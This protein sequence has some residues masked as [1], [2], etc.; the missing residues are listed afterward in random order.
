MRARLIVGWSTGVRPSTIHA[1][2]A[3]SM[4][5]YDTGT[6][7][8]PV[9]EGKEPGHVQTCCIR[10]YR[11]PRTR[12]RDDCRRHALLASPGGRDRGQRRRYHGCSVGPAVLARWMG[13]RSLP[14]GRA[15][16]LAAAS[17]P[18]LARPV[19]PHR[20]PVVTN[21]MVPPAIRGGQDHCWGAA[22][23]ISA[24]SWRLATC[25]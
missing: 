25:H 16:R 18:L 1:V 17:P 5:S 13:A 11:R 23:A 24:A 3:F 20:L 4:R 7:H 8:P 19:G 15:A 6:L 14:P 12:R 9:Q 21:T 2:Q 10:A 22:T